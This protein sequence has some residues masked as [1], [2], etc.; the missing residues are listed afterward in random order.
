MNELIKETVKDLLDDWVKAGTS[1]REDTEIADIIFRA[2][3]PVVGYIRHVQIELEEIKESVE[4][5]EKKGSRYCSVP[6]DVMIDSDSGG[7]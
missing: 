3:K 2:I 1:H 7:A 4:K 5:L 6:E